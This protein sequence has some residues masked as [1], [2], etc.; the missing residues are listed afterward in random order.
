MLELPCLPELPTGI[1][2][3]LFDCRHC[4]TLLGVRNEVRTA[5]IWA[6]P[7]K[8]SLRFSIVVRLHE[9]HNRLVTSG[10]F[11]RISKEEITPQ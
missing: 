4:W 9:S 2:V 1:D 7:V 10:V 3:C 6:E 5:A 11:D 8:R